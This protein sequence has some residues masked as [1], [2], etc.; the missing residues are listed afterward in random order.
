MDRLARLRGW[1][2]TAE[3]LATVLQE[4]SVSFDL[5][6][7]APN[8]RTLRLWRTEHVLS[9]TKPRRFTEREALE[10]LAM[11]R[12]SAE[13]LRVKASSIR[14][15]TLDNDGLRRLIV[16]AGEEAPLLSERGQQAAVAVQLLAQGVS[17]LYRQ[18]DAGSPTAQ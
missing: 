14:V 9:K 6:G 12:L 15:G 7:E 18:V 2:G 8:V 11:M 10:A 16:Q 17:L 13:G 5:S 1:E 3:E 4:I